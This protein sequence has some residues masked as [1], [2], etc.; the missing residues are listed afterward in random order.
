MYNKHL[1]R[2]AENNDRTVFTLVELDHKWVKDNSITENKTNTKPGQYNGGTQSK[3]KTVS[4][5]GIT[6]IMQKYHTKII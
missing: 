6:E 3:A 4:A 5:I 2:T 1:T